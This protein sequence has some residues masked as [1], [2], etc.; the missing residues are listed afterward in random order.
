[1]H[2]GLHILVIGRSILLK[3]LLS[4]H[5]NNY[6]CLKIDVFEK[7]IINFTL[8][9]EYY[10]YIIGTRERRKRQQTS[11]ETESDIS[12]DL[13]GAASVLM[14]PCVCGWGVRREDRNDSHNLHSL[15]MI[16]VNCVAC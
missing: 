5:Y 10:I 4:V 12:E 14:S 2:F 3:N 15:S 13:T 11:S 7:T 1:M 6:D 9:G 8:I 16:I